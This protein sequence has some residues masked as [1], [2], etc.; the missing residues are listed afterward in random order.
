MNF[1]LPYLIFI[2]IIN[3]IIFIKITYKNVGK[4]LWINVK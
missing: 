3:I 1:T 4:S 2:L